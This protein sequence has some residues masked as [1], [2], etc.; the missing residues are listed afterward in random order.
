MTGPYSLLVFLIAPEDLSKSPETFLPLLMAVLTLDIHC[1]STQATV[2]QEKVF[3][4]H[5]G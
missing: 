2:Q 1:A 5:S 4:T 3:N